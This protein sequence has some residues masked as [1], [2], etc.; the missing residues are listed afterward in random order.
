MY[1]VAY[2]SETRRILTFVNIGIVLATFRNSL[3][4]ISLIEYTLALS[5]SFE[6]IGAI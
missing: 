2:E 5:D 4:K 1:S 6:F 3:N